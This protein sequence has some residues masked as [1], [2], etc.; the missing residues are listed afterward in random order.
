MVKFSVTFQNSRRCIEVKDLHKLWGSIS[1]SFDKCPNF[2]KEFGI[3]YS[4]DG[5]YVE[6]GD[7]AQLNQRDS[8]NLRVVEKGFEKISKSYDNFSSS[9]DAD[10]S[11]GISGDDYAR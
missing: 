5:K 1:F 8:N 6:L 9:V 11:S 3:K 7:I 4:V 10:Q 2:P